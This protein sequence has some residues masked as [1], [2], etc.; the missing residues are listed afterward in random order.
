MKKP[1]LLIL[2]F[3]VLL[4]THGFAQ[5]RTI[6]GTV[7]AKDDNLPIPGVS[8]KVTGSSTGT[9]TDVNGR[10]SVKITSRATSITFSS[11]GFTTQVIP[12]GTS[13]TINVVLSSDNRQ[14][15]EVVVTALGINQQKRTLG[16]SQTTVK[17]ETMTESS[18]I[19]MLGGVQGKVAGVTISEKGS[20]PGGSTSVIIRGYSSIGGVNQPLYVIDGVPLDN[21]RPNQN[22]YYDFG[23]NANDVDPNN[24]ENISI[25]KG[26]EA[27][28]LYGTRGSSGVILITTKKGKAGKPK[29]DFS[30]STTLTNAAITFTPQK[31]FGQGWSGS[32]IL[33]ENGDWGPKY[34]GVLRPWGPTGLGTGATIGLQQLLKPF[35]FI[36]NNVSNAFDTGIELNNH[37]GISGGSETTTYN[38]SYT[39]VNS[40]GILPGN[41]D[42]FK[43]NEFAVTVGTKYKNFDVST[44]LNYTA[45]TSS[46][47]L[48]GNGNSTTLGN[49]FYGS[50]LQIPSDIPIKDLRDYKNLFF[51]T[52]NYFTPYAENPY[53]DLAENGA[54]YTTNH[55]FGN[56]NMNYRLTD[57]VKLN[58]QQS[59]DVSATYDKRW[60]NA[61]NP[62]PGSWNAGNN[63]EG[64]TRIAD[65]GSDF[66]ESWNTFEYDSK[67]QALFE[68]KISPS[69]TLNGI[70]GANYN[71]RGF[72]WIQT[73]VTNLTIP[74][75]YQIN[76]STVSP[77]SY[78]N[79]SHR[80]L[81]GFYG[82]ANLG[83]KDYLFLNVTG[84]N[85]VT[86]TLAP[87]HNSY[88]YPSASLSFILSQALGLKPSSG[89]TF[90]KLRAAYGRT[91]SDTDPYRIY[92]TLTATNIPVTFGR[93]Q[94]PLNNVAGYSVNNTLFNPSLQP[95]AIAETELGAELRFFDDR[96]SIDATY[97]NRT[98][99][100]Q[101]LE[102]P[103][104]PSSGYATEVENFGTVR[105]RGLELTVGGTPVK[106]KDVQWDITYLYSM[107]RS[108]VEELPAGLDK[109]VINNFYD[110]NMV[111]VKGQPLGVFQAPIPLMEN[112]HVVVNSTGI[113]VIDP[114]NVGDYGSIQPQF[115]MGLTNNVRV[116]DFTLG[117]T[118][119]YQQGGKFYSNS[120]Y[121]L[122]F[123]GANPETVYNDRNVFI[124]PNSVQ[125]NGTDANGK[126][127]YVENSTPIN[128]SNYYSYYNLSDNPA[129]AYRNIILTRT[130]VKLR[131]VTLGYN[132]PKAFVNRIGISNA[133]VSVFGRNLY[134]WLP[135]SNHIVDP[136]VGN[137][138]SDL[139]GAFGEDASGPPLRYYGARL[140]VSF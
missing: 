112:G 20:T 22:N 125:A 73:Y 59:A 130:F 64:A 30:T 124:V 81:I 61:N 89:I 34:D 87:G 96:L 79:T 1:I 43:K 51:N 82:Q 49:G 131:E 93:L 26:S 9:I 116:K 104:A 39:N 102:V 28:A 121:L 85:D 97:Y 13:N 136:E 16:Y 83:Y 127:V 27:T 50:L 72:S 99:K 53:Y 46:V 8:V 47:P 105:N 31:E 18:P 135:A 69:F 111:A 29:V 115:H 66:E 138:G 80:R 78:Q 10:Y 101:I 41:Y 119:D 120:A 24:I 107:D 62:A 106:T 6:T 5:N 126:P 36:E 45:R 114:N 86:S 76:N 71:D 11:V 48:S 118:I 139:A 4:V 42:L 54:H 60:S 15:G 109:V 38:I 110:V 68:K 133:K 12:I 74:S 23:N 25:L 17:G 84:R 128:H 40:N 92:N 117:F 37:I 33:S 75:F 77:I 98:R 90:A 108:L 52:D 129:M 140:N 58:F 55:V 123:V 70:L 103:I 7:T 19:D 113:P 35:S 32:F 63:V 44:S 67:L 56:I 2:S 122:S 14:L 94:F 95:E 100:K 21:S 134:T 91:G 65:V 132:L 137:L 3:L 88:F 57:W